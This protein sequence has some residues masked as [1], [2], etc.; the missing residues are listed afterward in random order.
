MKKL[1]AIVVTLIMVFAM[2]MTAS[3]AEM[4]SRKLDTLYSLAVTYI[5]REDYTKAM[6]YLNAALEICDETETAALY[7][8]IHLKKGCVYTLQQD[9][10]NAQKELD[11]AL[12]VDPSLSEAYLELNKHYYGGACHV[13]DEIAWEWMRIPHFYRDFYVYKYA[14][15]FSAA[16]TIADRILKEG[17][18]AV[19]DHLRF[20]SLGGSV[21]PIEALK[22][23]GV[24]MSS[25]AP[26]HRA[27]QV[28]A[29]T[30]DQLE[31][32]L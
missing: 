23:D 11:E 28:F 8:D 3:A 14:T 13:D 18:P 25:P 2:V 32:L 24:D 9:Y 20:L 6:E 29:E 21:P 22:T 17:E 12:R 15:S 10:E 26:V 30:V 1:V 19:Q 16:V 7:A 27:M 31:K 5:S 4:D